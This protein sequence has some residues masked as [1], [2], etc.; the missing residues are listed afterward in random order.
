M[1]TRFWTQRL[2]TIFE[3]WEVC[4]VKER[5]KKYEAADGELLTMELK[6][7]EGISLRAIK[8]GKRCFSYTFEKGEKA[9]SALLGNVTALMPFLDVDPCYALPPGSEHYPDLDLY[10]ETGLRTADGVKIDALLQM[11]STIRTV[12]RRITHTRNC[13][14]HESELHVGIINSRGLRAHAKKTIYTLG[15]MA[16][17]Q[18]GSDEVSWY[19]WSWA[20]RYFDLDG[21]KLGSQIGEKALSC[22]SGEVLTTGVYHGL[23]TPA[24]ACQ[25]LE[26]L[27]PSFLS[28]NL[29]KNKTCLRDKIGTRCFSAPLTVIDSGLSGLEAFPF[30]GEGVPSQENVLVKEGVLQAFLYDTYYAKR[31]EKVSTG[32]SVRHGIKEPPRCGS[33]GFFI[34][35]GRGDDPEAGSGGVIIEE[36]MGAHMANTITGDFSLG[37]IGHYYS[38]DTLVPFKGVILSGNLFDLLGQVLAVGKDLTF[39]GPYGSPTLLVEALKISGR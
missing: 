37:A 25:I 12:D 21:R 20:S 5:A 19:D 9:V 8:D 24:C 34:D 15:A 7:E 35:R 30:D 22:L 2:E 36:L 11:E 33:R 27:S 17:A 18:D 1:D 31:M 16:V 14:L 13:E 3:D 39:Y 23:L 6:E 10:D 26:I 4:L 29:Y 32:N 38:G 28:E